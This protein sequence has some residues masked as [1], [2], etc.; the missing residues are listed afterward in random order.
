MKDG[1]FLTIAF[2]SSCD[3]TAVAVLAEGRNVLSNVISTQIEIH[4]V[5][6]G[7]VPEIASRHHLENINAVTEQALTEAGVTWEEIDLI[8]VTKGP[9]LVGALLVGIAT[10]KA[11][12]MAK[13]KPLVGVHHIEGHVSAN[14]IEHRDLEPPSHGG[15]ALAHVHRDGAQLRRDGAAGPG[16]RIFLRPVQHLRPVRPGPL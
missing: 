11:F 10:A 2:E 6:G 13:K 8:G 9:G 15:G 5:F 1:K 12:A 16:G 14:Y 4:K 3:E 7:V